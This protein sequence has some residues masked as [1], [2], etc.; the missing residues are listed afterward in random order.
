MACLCCVHSANCVILLTCACVSLRV[1]IVFRLFSDSLLCVCVRM[2]L[3][4]CVC[5]RMCLCVCVCVRMCLCVFVFVCVC[6]CVC[7]FV[8]VSTSEMSQVSILHM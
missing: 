5:V 2:C 8:C 1:M 4:V 3:C 6:V 7:V